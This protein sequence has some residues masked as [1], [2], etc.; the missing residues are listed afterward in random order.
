MDPQG[1][2][3]NPMLRASDADRDRAASV[4]NSA[5][6]EGRLTAEEH[7]DRLD[8]IYAAKTN[9]DIV[10]Y[11]ADLPAHMPGSALAPRPATS[12]PVVPGRK[13]RIVAIMSGVTRKGFWRA[14]PTMSV[15]ALVG[16]AE[17]DFRDAD[18]PAGE[19]TLK[20]TCLLGGMK[21]TVPPEMRVVDSG[22]SIMGGHDIDGETPESAAADAPVLR[23]TGTCI[24]GGIEVKRKAR[25]APGA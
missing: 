3:D 13:D 8:G 7:S 17:L 6:A 1:Y 12:A 10:L 22:I 16:G 5:M 4:L 25:Q 2:S 14:E 20:A 11:L 18:L 24:M 15:F 19:I 9:A 23:I 21:I